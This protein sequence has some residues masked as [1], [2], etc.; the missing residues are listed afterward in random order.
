M[1]LA[2][3]EQ[4]DRADAEIPEDLGAEADF[5]PF[6]VARLGFGMGFA[7]LVA[8]LRPLS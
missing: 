1:A 7:A 6:A 5:Q 2:A 3:G 8:G 4:F